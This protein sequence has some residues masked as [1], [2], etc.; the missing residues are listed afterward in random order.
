MI[1]NHYSVREIQSAGN[2]CAARWNEGVGEHV[3][4]RFHFGFERR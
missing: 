4:T 1:Q 2:I 3:R